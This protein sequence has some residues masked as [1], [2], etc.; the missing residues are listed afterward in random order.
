MTTIDRIKALAQE[1]GI[2]LSFLCKKMNVARVY[3]NDIQKHGRDISPDKLQIIA[4]CL[5]TTVPYLLGLTEQ[6]EKPIVNDEGLGENQKKL[7]ELL[8]S[9]PDDLA[10]DV[11]DH[12]K[13]Y[14]EHRIKHLK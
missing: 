3:F 12:M 5:N 9:L 1:K 2:S 11:M 8:L 7:Y 6:K 14:L 10:A 4:D 13:T